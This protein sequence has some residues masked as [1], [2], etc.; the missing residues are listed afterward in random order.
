MKIIEDLQESINDGINQVKQHIKMEGIQNV[1]ESG[2]A[3]KLS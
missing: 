3:K 1:H 2:R